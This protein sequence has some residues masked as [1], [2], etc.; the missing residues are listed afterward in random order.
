MANKCDCDQCNRPEDRIKLESG[1]S[2]Y[3]FGRVVGL[4]IDD[5]FDTIYYGHDGYIGECEDPL[6]DKEKEE[7]C[8]LM[9]QKWT[10]Y[11]KVIYE[12]KN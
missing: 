7:I 9:I 5:N 3:T 12:R 6:T 8:L 11:L 10:E 1:R 2:V 4:S